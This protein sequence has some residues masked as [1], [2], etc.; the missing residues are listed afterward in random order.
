MQTVGGDD[1]KARADSL[2]VIQN[3]SDELKRRVTAR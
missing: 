1:S 3:W 2:T